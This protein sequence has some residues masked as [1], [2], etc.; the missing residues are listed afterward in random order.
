[1]INKA[2]I[3]AAGLGSRLGKLS[4]EKPKALIEVDGV[5]LLERTIISLKDNGINHFMINVHHFSQLVVDFLKENNN[6]G[7]HVEIS[8]ESDSLL[9]T[10]GAIKKAAS[11]FNKGELV[12]VHNVDVM[13]EVNLKELESSHTRSKALVTLSVRKRES[14]R[15]L[16]FSDKMN[17]IGWMSKPNKSYK[18]VHLPEK[19]Y[20]D[21]AFSGIY[22]ADGIFANLLPFH[23]RFSIIDAWLTMAATERIIGFPDQSPYWF[24]LG[25]SEK[26]RLAEEYFSTRKNNCNN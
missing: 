17:L 2:F 3:L 4:S 14:T 7:V 15:A 21:F 12:L 19:S 23:G 1:M 11:F 6:F 16:L 20:Q 13:S 26:I 8:D 18:W 22:L 9:D 5:P 10:G 25:T 24:D